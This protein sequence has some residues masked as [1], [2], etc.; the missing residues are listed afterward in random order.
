MQ[1][2]ILVTHS[3]AHIRQFDQV[4][5]LRRGIVLEAG[6]PGALLAREDTELGKL[7][8]GHGTRRS[9]TSGASTPRS[10]GDDETTTL[11]ASSPAEEKLDDGEAL[12]GPRRES[13]GRAALLDTLPTK[14]ETEMNKEHR[15]QGRC[16]ASMEDAY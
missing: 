16:S 3:I 2:R 10:S 12:K 5:Y 8:R 15:E 14:Q 7:V 6:P 9:G 1:A 4:L 11:A 13:F